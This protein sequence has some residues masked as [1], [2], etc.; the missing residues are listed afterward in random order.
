MTT[1]R[2][3]RYAGWQLEALAGLLEALER[4]GQALEQMADETL[5]I[6][7]G[8]M[9]LQ[10]RATAIDS[11]ATETDRRLVLALLG[12]DA[13]KREED[14]RLLAELVVP[15]DSAALQSAAVAALGR[16]ADPRVPQL[17]AANWNTHSPA[18]KGQILNVLLSRDAWQ[19]RLLNLIQK[20]TVAA[21]EIDAARRQRLLAHRQEAIR[22]LAAKVFEGA[23]NADRRKVLDD[24]K[25]ANTLIG[26]S[27]RGK[28]VFA[29]SCSICH[30]VEDIGHTVGPDLQ[31]LSN[32]SPLYLLTEI[33]DPNRNVDSRYLAYVAVTRSG[34]TFTGLLAS[35][36]ATSIILRAQEGKEEVLLRS[37]LDELQSSGKSL[38]PEGSEKELS[39]Q[40]VA[41]LIA[42]LTAFQSP[43]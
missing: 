23:I 25:E 34:R 43:R 30:R 41:D 24:Y 21:A 38:M 16:I 35:E 39:K 15:Q 18:L 12:R 4:R 6:P 11:K 28:A 29:K 20:R 26:D 17:L 40:D 36:S 3:G 27:R 32:K 19:H 8:R 9:F 2:E 42:Y 33:L 7:I 5:R 22:T 13:K 14:M 1:L 10:A 37:E 31:A